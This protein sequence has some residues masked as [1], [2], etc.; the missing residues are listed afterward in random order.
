[1]GKGEFSG[2]GAFRTLKQDSVKQ[3]GWIE[4]FDN[5]TYKPYYYHTLSKQTLWSLP[6][7]AFVDIEGTFRWKRHQFSSMVQDIAGPTEIDENGYENRF[8]KLL[9]D[10]SNLMES[11]FNK[12]N[13]L[14]VSDLHKKALRINF[15]NEDG[16][17]AGK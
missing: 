15:V 11:S 10:R 8:Q 16:I 4:C 2:C 3:Q 5:T 12:L 1:M 6:Q 9:I 13:Q 17:D 14:S 7:G